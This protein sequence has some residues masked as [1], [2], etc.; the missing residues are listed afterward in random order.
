MRV[1]MVSVTYGRKINLGDYN[2]A[3]I[4]CDLWAD[5]DEGDDL[6]RCMAGLWDMAKANVKAQALP[7]KRNLEAQVEQIFLGL[8][9]ELRDEINANQGAD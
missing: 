3:N 7:L 5:I 6:D 9:V 2:S 4:E 1:K 8:P